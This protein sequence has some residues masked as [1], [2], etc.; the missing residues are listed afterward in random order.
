M[1]QL[2]LCSMQYVKALQT[3]ETAVATCREAY[4]EDHPRTAEAYS[5][6]AA[7]LRKQ[8]R[9][10]EAHAA[11]SRV[12]T[13]RRAVLGAEHPLTAEAL[14]NLGLLLQDEDRMAEARTVF[15]AA[16]DAY[17]QLYGPEHTRTRCAQAR[18]DALEK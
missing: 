5:G 15:E 11:Y 9:F 16:R 18:L 4:G 17:M 2:Y 3:S 7:V 14:L 10:A 1:S 6:L 12:L 13:I 8:A